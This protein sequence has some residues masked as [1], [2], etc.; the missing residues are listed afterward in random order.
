V[1]QL[2]TVTMTDSMFDSMIR[3]LVSQGNPE[4]KPI[5]LADYESWQKLYTFDALLDQRYGQSFCNHFDIQDHRIFYE[6]DWTRCD[7]L[8]RSEWIERP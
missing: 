5:K 2:D 1:L 7:K 3:S 8:I 4:A 6:R